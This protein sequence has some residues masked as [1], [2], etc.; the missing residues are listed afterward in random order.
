M[1]DFG[2]HAD[3]AI[4]VLI[5][6]MAVSVALEGIES[7]PGKALGYVLGAAIALTLAVL[8]V[9]AFA[10]GADRI[11]SPMPVAAALVALE[12]L[13]LALRRRF[14]LA[15]FL[16]VIG[17]AA[18]HIALVP[19]GEEVPGGLPVLVALY[20]IG[21]R[22]ERRTSL[23]LMLLTGAIVAGTGS[24]VITGSGSLSAGASL[25]GASSAPPVT[26]TGALSAGAASVGA[27]A[28]R[29]IGTASLSAA[30]IL[31]GSGG[32]TIT[33]TGALSTGA[34]LWGVDVPDVLVPPIGA[35]VVSV[36]GGRATGVVTGTAA[37]S[38][39]HGRAHAIV[40]EPT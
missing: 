29:F 27:G 15:V 40:I 2:R 33:G 8:S 12:T 5:A 34:R 6:V 3:R 26:G 17:A 1:L 30:A 16:T 37:A 25:F 4:Y 22:L 19:V 10:S 39:I 32:E 9:L 13:P 28:E 36:L 20:T 14:P 7:R 31:A 38:I 11:D 35:P 23:G 18:V 21:E 24:L